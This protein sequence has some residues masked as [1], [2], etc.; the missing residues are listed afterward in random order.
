MEISTDFDQ[1]RP[2]KF[3][4]KRILAVHY[5][6]IKEYYRIIIKISENRRSC[7]KKVEKGRKM[8]NGAD[9]SKKFFRGIIEPQKEIGSPRGLLL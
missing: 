5:K 6:K 4:L 3:F 2:K 9:F 7:R 8:S 1:F